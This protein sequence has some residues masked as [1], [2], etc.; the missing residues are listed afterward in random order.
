MNSAHCADNQGR[1]GGDALLR[2]AVPVPAGRHV[3]RIGAL[4]VAL[5]IGAWV[6]AM[7]AAAVA[8]TRGAGE[9]SDS[10]ASAPG[11]R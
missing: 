5:G 7:P 6:A 9:S 11:S 1:T 4:A 2:S 8:D 3:G 10:S